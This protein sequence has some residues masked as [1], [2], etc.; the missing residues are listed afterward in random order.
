MGI[1]VAEMLVKNARWNFAM[2]FD[3][4]WNI[5]HHLPP[6][7]GLEHKLKRLL[8][9]PPMQ[10]LFLFLLQIC[11]V[12]YFRLLDIFFIP[13]SHPPNSG[14]HYGHNIFVLVCCLYFSLCEECDA[15]TIFL[16]IRFKLCKKKLFVK[17]LAFT[18]IVGT[19]VW[20]DDGDDGDDDDDD[21]DDGD[22]LRHQ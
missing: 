12:I 10:Q 1:P 8:C 7:I 18:Q 4:Q 6:N 20:D 5:E 21:D 13:Q 17:S 19:I 15:G 2:R 22:L 14:G 3:L 9:A 11:F 16:L